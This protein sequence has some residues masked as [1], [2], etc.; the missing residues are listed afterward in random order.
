MLALDHKL[1]LSKKIMFIRKIV[2]CL[3][4]ISL[5]ISISHLLHLHSL[6]QLALSAAGDSFPEAE[7][8]Y[9]FNR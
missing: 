7:I 5:S 9:I 3:N 8:K 1:L 6:F 2:L 4:Y